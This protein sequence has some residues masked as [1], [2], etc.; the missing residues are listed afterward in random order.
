MLNCSFPSGAV[1]IITSLSFFLFLFR[2]QVFLRFFVLPHFR[3]QLC[4]LGM[5]VVRNSFDRL[6][7]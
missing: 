2:S 6:L 3:F 1:I 5:L 4:F 7:I